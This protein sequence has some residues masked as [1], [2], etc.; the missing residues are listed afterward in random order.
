MTN[1][2]SVIGAVSYS[3]DVAERVGAILSP[4]GQFGFG[5]NS[6]NGRREKVVYPNG[7]KAGL[8]YDSMDRVVR[9]DYSNAAAILIMSSWGGVE[10]V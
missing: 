7:L 5:Y 1:A 10:R 4:A 2:A 3:N 8:T 9:L 6:W